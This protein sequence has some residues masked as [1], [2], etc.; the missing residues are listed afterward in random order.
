MERIRSLT[1]SDK[2]DAAA[3]WKQIFGD[4]DGFID[5]FFAE[6]YCPDQSVCL[7]IDGRIASMM[8]GC[9]MTIA[10]RGKPVRAMM[11]S[12]VSTLP[13]YRGRGLMHRV[14]GEMMQVARRN[15]CLAVFDKPQNLPT[16]FSLGHLPCTDTLHFVSDADTENPAW[17]DSFDIPAL[18]DCYR[19]STKHYSG[20]VIRSEAEM[21]LKMRDYR[22]DGGRILTVSDAMGIEAYC[23]GFMEEEGVR[24]EEVLSRSAD[25]Y[26]RILSLLPRGT[27]AKLPPDVPAAGA[28]RPQNVIGAADIPALLALLVGDASVVV[29]VDD[30][31]VLQN[32][33][34][35]N[36][37]G[38]R[39]E[40]PPQFR[41]TAGELMQALSGYRPL[42]GILS[43]AICYCVDEY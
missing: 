30:P 23:V 38:E 32:N 21:A 1:P 27:R 24:C 31:V 25:G 10:L 26:R 3:L 7:E 22:S 6:R 37:R 29:S 28:V 15:D 42:P 17:S 33:G 5:W 4:S 13:E 16:F 36:G 41:Y 20:C 14:M 35:F 2:A 34:V 18:T 12:G 40:R 11:I 19:E 8:Q 43:A 39:T 9:P